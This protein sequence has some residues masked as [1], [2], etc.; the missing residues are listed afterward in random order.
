MSVPLVA[1]FYRRPR[2]WGAIGVLLLLTG[3]S[4]LFT[5]EIPKPLEGMWHLITLGKERRLLRGLLD[6]D[7]LPSWLN[8]PLYAFSL[9]SSAVI[10]LKVTDIAGTAI[11]QPL[12]LFVWYTFAHFIVIMAV[13]LFD[14]WAS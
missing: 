14:P 5:P 7:F 11:E 12:G 10:I 6:S 13:W 9:F 4:V 3:S 8:H 1:S 2:F